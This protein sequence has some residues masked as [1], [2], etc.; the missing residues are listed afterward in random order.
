M[1]ASVLWKPW[2][3]C[4]K[5]KAMKAVRNLVILLGDQL[6]L[7]SCVLK[8][9]DPE[10]DIVWMAEVSEES[11]H[12]W[13]HKQKITL[14]LSAMRHFKVAV[15]E[16]GVS[17][18]YTELEPN[19]KTSFS[20][21]LRASLDRHKPKAVLCMRP[22]EWRVLNAIERVCASA[23]LPFELFEDDHFFV[24]PEAFRAFAQNRKSIRMEYFYRAIRKEQGVLMEGSNPVGGAWNFDKENRKSF[25]KGGP[26]AP[27]SGP[28]HEPDAITK[29]VMDQVQTEF[30]EHPGD[31][32]HFRWAV[33][34]E[35]A[36]EDLESFIRDRLP[37]FGDHQ[38]AMW[39]EEPW[40]FHSLLSPS[41]NLKLLR[42]KEVVDAAQ[43]AYEDG[44]APLA[45]VE[46]FIRQIL[47]W[48]EYVRG[49]YWLYMPEYLERNTL[50]ADRALPD[51]YWTGETEFEC[52]R[53]SIGQT[54]KYGYAH[55]IQRLMVT[56]LFA[57]LFGVRPKA[58]HAWYLAV[59]VDA[60]EWVELPNS[61]GMSQYADGGLMASKPYVA[62]GK[63]IDRMSN[64]CAQCPK[65]PSQRVGERA[66]PFT[67]LYW[68]FLLRHEDDL[69]K[70]PRMQL[71]VRNIDRIEESERSAIQSQA[72]ALRTASNSERH[73]HA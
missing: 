36:L 24:T 53:Q 70:N 64:Y 63:Y 65:D 49:V 28:V 67:T 11:T 18:D 39:T 30:K 16:R 31:L 52:L 57:L 13:S 8:D 34:R 38:D 47:G 61:L 50:G 42:P 23:K 6:D 35:E 58:V 21:V 68:D 4:L 72:R 44:R 45:S 54:L 69:R 27:N 15:S 71:Q 73:A 26:T 3:P 59:Y 25:G 1:V 55:H 19:K 17:I 29:A 41:L 12:V 62:T 46:G 22:G 60:V 32:T 43:R 9:L 2:R 66:C 56:G 20:S 10:Q 33:T 51:F 40:L 7:D 37:F 14:F 48:R 5:F